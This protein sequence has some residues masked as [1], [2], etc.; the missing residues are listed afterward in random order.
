MIHEDRNSKGYLKLPHGHAK[1]GSKWGKS[2]EAHCQFC[3]RTYAS[4]DLWDAHRIKG[5]CQDPIDTGLVLAG[6]RANEAWAKPNPDE[7]PLA[8][9]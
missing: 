2:E 7:L 1:C 8:W 9:R 4:V 6:G 3:C 5:V